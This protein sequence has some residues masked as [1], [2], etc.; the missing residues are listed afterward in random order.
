MHDRL[1]GRTML[2]DPAGRR[3]STDERV[4]Q[5]ADARVSDEYPHRRDPEREPIHD[6]IGRPRWCPAGLT[7]SQKRRVQRLRQ[8]EALEEERKEA[9]RRGVKL[10]IWRVKP[11]ANDKQDSGSSAAPINTITMLPPIQAVGFP[12]RS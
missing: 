12:N 1:G 6:N 8:I 2:R 3:I 4:E 5:T 9:P 11:K 7:R 10:E